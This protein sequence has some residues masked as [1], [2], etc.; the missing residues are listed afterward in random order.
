MIRY[1]AL[2]FGPIVDNNPI[3]LQILGICSALAVTTSVATAL[4]MGASLTIVLMISNGLI[5]VIRNHVPASVRLIVQ[6]TIVASL[7]IVVD[8]LLKAYAYEISQRLSIFVGLIVSNCLVLGRIEDL[9]HA[10]SALAQHARRPR[11][12]PRLCRGPFCRGINSGAFRRRKLSRCPGADVS[13]FEPHASC[14]QRFLSSWDFS[15]GSS[16]VSSR[17]R[18]RNPS[19]MPLRWT[20]RAGHERDLFQGRRQREPR[21]LLFPWHLYFPCHFQTALHGHRGRSGRHCHSDGDR[22]RELSAL[23]IR[24]ESRRAWLARSRRSRSQFPA[25]HCLHRS[26][27]CVGTDPRNG[28]RA[29]CTRSSIGHLASSSRC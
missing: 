14:P 5:S 4:T 8:Q 25:P 9:R 22:A 3:T 1:K 24:A 11:Q 12:R 15:S 17:H 16:A 6:I 13:A 26:Y 23:H 2:L 18:W 28:N 7:V 20:W 29:I 19:F 10:K 21:P 27:C